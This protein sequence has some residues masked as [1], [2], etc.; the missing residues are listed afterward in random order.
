MPVASHVLYLTTAFCIKCYYCCISCRWKATPP[1]PS[2][3]LWVSILL[4]PLLLVKIHHYY[5]LLLL[6]HQR[7]HEM[8]LC[9]YFDDASADSKEEIMVILVY[10]LQKSMSCTMNR[11]HTMAQNHG[12]LVPSIETM[13]LLKYI[14][15][16][17][18]F[19][20]LIWR[21][22]RSPVLFPS[23]R[24]LRLNVASVFCHHCFIR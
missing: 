13:L 24:N 1:P 18:T 6:N 16:R 15:K 8:D 12:K 14:S 17:N 11:K 3:V 19:G 23:S 5:H 21:D 9:N 7:P 2:L 10:K 22:V 4:P 20:P